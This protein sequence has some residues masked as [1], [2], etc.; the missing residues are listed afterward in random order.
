MLGL[1]LKWFRCEACET[2]K[3]LAE[4]AWRSPFARGFGVCGTCYERWN[5]CG[6][7]CPRCWA[8]VKASQFLAFFTEWKR[9][10][11]FECGGALLA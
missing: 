6:R 7:R 1:H 11:H 3:P 8:Q 2:F 9:F 10:G 4:R 5:Q